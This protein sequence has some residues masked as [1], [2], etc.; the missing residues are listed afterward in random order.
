MIKLKHVLMSYI[1]NYVVTCTSL[2][3]YGE[4]KYGL[5]V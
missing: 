3:G 4:H 1:W 2:Q 5:W